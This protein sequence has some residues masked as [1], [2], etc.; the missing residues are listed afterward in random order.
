[1]KNDKPIKID[2]KEKLIERLKGIQS[3]IDDLE[4]QRSEKIMKLAKKFNLFDLSDKTIESEFSLIKAKYASIE[5][6]DEAIDK[7]KKN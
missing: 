2:K 4:N 6:N 3:K 7:S 1:M 5:N